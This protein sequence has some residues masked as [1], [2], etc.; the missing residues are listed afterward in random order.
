MGIYSNHPSLHSFIYNHKIVIQLALLVSILQRVIK[1]SVNTLII[2]KDMLS[3]FLLS[4]YFGHLITRHYTI[5]F[6]RHI[7][8]L[9]TVIFISRICSITSRYDQFFRIISTIS[10]LMVIFHLDFSLKYSC[11]RQ[12]SQAKLK[13]ATHGHTFISISIS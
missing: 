12:T 3:F 5:I 6:E 1:P 11:I 4:F 13:Q 9:S 7:N 8:V 10:L 2:F